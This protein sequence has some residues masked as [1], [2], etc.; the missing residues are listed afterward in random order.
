MLAIV[1]AMICL[2]V[3]IVPLCMLIGGFLRRWKAKD[4]KSFKLFFTVAG[5]II[6]AVFA[7]LS[8]AFIRLTYMK[9]NCRGPEDVQYYALVAFSCVLIVVAAGLSLFNLY[10]KRAWLDIAKRCLIFLLVLGFLVTSMVSLAEYFGIWGGERGYSAFGGI[11]GLCESVFAIVKMGI[12]G[13][14][15]VYVGK[16]TGGVDVYLAIDRHTAYHFLEEKLNTEYV[17]FRD[18]PQFVGLVRCIVRNDY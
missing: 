4:E 12:T 6:L 8:F 11:K 5:S 14:D 7:V 18:Q 17:L 15:V 3:G 9:A 10:S 1:F 13:D 2:L 16:G